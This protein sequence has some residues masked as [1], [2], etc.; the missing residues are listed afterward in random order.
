[1]LIDV[2][3]VDLKGGGDFLR[4]YENKEELKTEIKKEHLRNIFQN[5]II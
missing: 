3:V 2:N 5:L 4:P 1:M